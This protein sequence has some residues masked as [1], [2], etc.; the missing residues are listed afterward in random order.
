MIRFNNGLQ[1]ILAGAIV[2]LALGIALQA[3]PAHG[4]SNSVGE[5]AAQAASEGGKHHRH[6]PPGKAFYH[7]QPHEMPASTDDRSVS[8]RRYG[9]VSKRLLSFG[10][11]TRAQRALDG[12][13]AGE[14]SSLRRGPPGKFPRFRS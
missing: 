12:D 13:T 4:A 7:A 11:G 10:P 14:S 3:K 1:S 2:V 6:G 5:T 9:P 8:S